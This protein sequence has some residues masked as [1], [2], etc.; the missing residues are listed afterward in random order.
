MDTTAAMLIIVAL[1]V[2][3]AAGWFFGNRPAADWKARHG[4]REEEFKRAVAELGNQPWLER[5]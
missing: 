3:L 4:E 5:A 1:A 2:G